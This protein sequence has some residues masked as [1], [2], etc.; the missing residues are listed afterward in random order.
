MIFTSCVD[1]IPVSDN[2]AE[3][4]LYLQCEVSPDNDIKAIVS[5]TGVLSGNQLPQDDKEAFV[6]LKDLSNGL[7]I[8]MVYDLDIERYQVKGVQVE[9]GQ[10]FRLS[11]ESEDL[12]AIEAGAVVPFRTELVETAA[13]VNQNEV[14]LNMTIDDLDEGRYYHIIPR[15]NVYSTLNGVD[16]A[17]TGD[18]IH[19][20]LDESSSMVSF[21]D[22]YHLDGFLVDKDL[23]TS[24]NIN[25]TLDLGSVLG[26]S[27]RVEYI[28]YDLRTVN[29]AY[30]MFHL[31]IS[32]QLK[33]ADS[34]V[35]NPVVQ[36]TNVDNGL[37]YFGA[38]TSNVDSVL[39]Q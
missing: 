36:Y 10:V 24:N 2:G 21:H 20:N 35:S 7:E 5:R 23:L 26:S 25:S 6:M 28:N 27:Q 29:E 19:L 12:P 3:Q 37:G 13:I 9:E 33:A 18:Y 34:P 30:Y 15:A 31:S 8:E 1:N 14:T 17:Y 11:V 38:F 39:V 16:F 32:K 22:L 4:K